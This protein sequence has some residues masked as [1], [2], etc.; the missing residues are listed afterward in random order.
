MNSPTI[1]NKIASLIHDLE[2]NVDIKDRKANKNPDPDDIFYSDDE[3]FESDDD[4][5]DDEETDPD[6]PSMDYEDFSQLKLLKKIKHKTSKFFDS[7]E[8]TLSGLC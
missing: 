4:D 6:L 1:A 2:E 7:S 5:E 3:I 8:N